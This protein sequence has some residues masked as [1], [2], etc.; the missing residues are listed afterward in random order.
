MEAFL[1]QLDP[2]TVFNQYRDEPSPGQ[3]Q[4]MVALA[5]RNVHTG[6]QYLGLKLLAIGLLE[7][8]AMVSGGDAPV[9]LLMGG[10]EDAEDARRME[11]LLPDV[12]S[13]PS[14]DES[15]TLF[16]LLAF[17][18]ASSSS[19]DMQNSPLSLF[20]FKVLGWE[21]ARQL[22]GQAKLMFDDQIDAA[23]FL[24]RMP[25]SVV[26]PVAKASAELASTRRATLMAYA[27]MRLRVAG[28]QPA[29]HRS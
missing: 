6:R 2:E 18:R 17:G 23:T 7:G 19:F 13:V 12:S 21:H 15:S 22:L 1:N 28:L 26:V 11:D 27:E 20:L 3:Y 24:E 14:V 25:A 10:I 9:A 4:R 16:G 29:I 8:L 5:H